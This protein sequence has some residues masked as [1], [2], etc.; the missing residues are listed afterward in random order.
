MAAAIVGLAAG[1][2][3]GNA[4][5]SAFGWRLP[6]F[7]GCLLIPFLFII[8]SRVEETEAFRNRVVPENL[9]AVHF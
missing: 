1:L 4:R 5:M 8:R 6:F 7:V 3:L 2:W 9:I